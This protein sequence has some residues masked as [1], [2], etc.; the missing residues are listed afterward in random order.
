MNDITT[1]SICNTEIK[2]VGIKGKI[3]LRKSRNFLKIF[4]GKLCKSKY[5]QSLKFECFFSDCNKKFEVYSK[6]NTHY[7]YHVNTLFN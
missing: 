2:D 4:K 1:A 7:F 3:K 6:W 5:D